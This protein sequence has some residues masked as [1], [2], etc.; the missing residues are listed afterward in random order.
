MYPWKTKPSVGDLLSLV[1]KGALSRHL[2]L[3]PD[4]VATRKPVL[5][6]PGV[7]NGFGSPPMKG[8]SA[9]GV[10]LGGFLRCRC[11]N[12]RQFRTEPPQESHNFKVL[13]MLGWRRTGLYLWHMSADW[14]EEFQTDT[15]TG[16][17]DVLGTNLLPLQG[18]SLKQVVGMAFF[19]DAGWWKLSVALC[20]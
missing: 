11:L 8:C 15:L 10:E 7:I 12:T 18:D 13:P 16:I 2:N 9:I 17:P 5:W 14:F 6:H 19:F 3:C 20:L 1:V 4:G